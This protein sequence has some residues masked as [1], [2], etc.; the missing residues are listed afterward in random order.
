MSLR[1]IWQKH[2]ADK[3]PYIEFYSKLFP[4]GFKINKFLE[5]GVLNGGSLKMWEEYFPKAKIYGI[6]IKKKSRFNS[7]RITTIQADQSD[8]LHLYRI[9]KEFGNFDV[10]LDDGGH[11]MSQQ[12]ISFAILFKFLKSNGIYII[13]DLHTS[14]YPQ[15][16]DSK[17]TT[18]DM[19]DGLTRTQKIQSE[20]IKKPQCQYLE[21]N[22]KQHAVYTPISNAKPCL[23]AI[24]VKR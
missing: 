12:Q 17:V 11:Y 2:K 18:Y 1:K 6:D 5:I 3:G 7:K 16:I 20:F 8:R 9:G 24:F 19:V 13:E 23:A 4:P 15:Y 22:I 10:I 14:F 21:N